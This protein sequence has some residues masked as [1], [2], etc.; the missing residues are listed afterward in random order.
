MLGLG[1]KFP[2]LAKELLGVNGV[3]VEIRG[4][5]PRLDASDMSELTEVSISEVGEMTLGGD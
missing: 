1:S 5:Q 2:R 3:G 4:A